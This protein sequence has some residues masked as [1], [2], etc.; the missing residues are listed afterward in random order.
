MQWLNSNAIQKSS[1]A[2]SFLCLFLAIMYSGF[3]VTLYSSQEELM[4]EISNDAKAEALEPSRGSSQ[5]TLHPSGNYVGGSMES[6]KKFRSKFI[7]KKNIPE[8]D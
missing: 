6:P 1:T 7:T 3:A 2:F 4:E 8:L 5:M